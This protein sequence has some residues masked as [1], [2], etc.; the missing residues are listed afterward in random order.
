MR[1]TCSAD[2]IEVSETRTFNVNKRLSERIQT[3][4][5]IH[6]ANN[7]GVSDDADKAPIVA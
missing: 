4:H 5:L 1:N 6:T 2:A 3:R 7:E